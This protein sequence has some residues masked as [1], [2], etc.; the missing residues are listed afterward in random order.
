MIIDGTLTT[1]NFAILETLDVS[2]I[3]VSNIE[4]YDLI[5]GPDFHLG[6]SN[7]ISNIKIDHLS[8]INLN[9]CNITADTITVNNELIL[10]D[11]ILSNIKIYGIN[12][13]DTFSISNN[14]IK[15]RSNLIIGD[16]SSNVR[17]YDLGTVNSGQDEELQMTIVI[18]VIIM[19]L[20][21]QTLLQLQ[22]YIDIQIF[23]KSIIFYGNTEQQHY[24]IHFK[25]NYIRNENCN[26]KD[27]IEKSYGYRS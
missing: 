20:M 15:I 18:L 3:T 22:I 7:F 2:N 11:A 25:N 4:I 24:D 19:E 5:S 10:G 17:R 14:D 23:D 13:D 8:N 1:S 21:I 12:I 6:S 16:N 26:I 27:E 9:S